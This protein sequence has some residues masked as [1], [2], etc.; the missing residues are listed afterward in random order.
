MSI[1]LQYVCV[2]VATFTICIM[3]IWLIVDVIDVYL[4]NNQKEE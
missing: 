3:L 4:T 1:T 2:G